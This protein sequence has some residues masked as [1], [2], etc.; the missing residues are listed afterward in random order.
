MAGTPSGSSL[1]KRK[2]RQNQKHKD[3]RIDTNLK[4]YGMYNLIH[5][6]DEAMVRSAAR[7]NHVILGD[8]PITDRKARKLCGAAG[9]RAQLPRNSKGSASLPC[10]ERLQHSPCILVSML[11][12]T[13]FLFIRY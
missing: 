9:K 13:N 1:G 12:F 6:A 7:R 5:K 11:M 2:R 10:S 8:G 3:K 4:G